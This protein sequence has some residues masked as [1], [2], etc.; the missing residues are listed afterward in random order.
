[1]PDSDA[2][3]IDDDNF[4]LPPEL[5]RPSVHHATSYSA[6]TTSFATF[7]EPTVT[8]NNF[9]S[10]GPVAQD[11]T[12]SSYTTLFYDAVSPSKRPRKRR[13][14]S[15]EASPRQASSP[16]GRMRHVSEEHVPVYQLDLEK[17]WNA[18]MSSSPAQSSPSMRKIE[19]SHTQSASVSAAGGLFGKSANRPGKPLPM[20][21]VAQQQSISVPCSSGTSGVK[22]PR[23]PALAAHTVQASISVLDNKRHAHLLDEH[24]APRRAFSATISQPLAGLMDLELDNDEPES[25]A[26]LESS[27][28]AQALAKRQLSRNLRRKDGTD[29][30]KPIRDSSGILHQRESIG[31]GL[32]AMAALTANANRPSVASPLR[33]AVSPA[34]AQECVESPSARWLK[35]TGMPGFGDNE[36]HGKTLPC[37]KV[38]EDGLMRITTETVRYFDRFF[39]IMLIDH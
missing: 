24:H 25:E 15:P 19:R 33:K 20:L 31:N 14:L 7:D 34:R 36:A 18:D 22:R 10:G 37:E 23:R 3:D 13:S 35:G 12:S 5:T 28:A 8:L 17:A 2:M 6:S 26:N 11:T 38:S 39:Y 30:F 27:P 9:A 4:I 16:E 1:M 32:S 21:G 29:D